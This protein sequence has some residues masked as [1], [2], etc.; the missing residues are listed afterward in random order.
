MESQAV[1]PAMLGGVTMSLSLP[2]NLV[3]QYGHLQE[4]MG[5]RRPGEVDVTCTVLLETSAVTASD[6]FS[7]AQ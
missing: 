1:H 4:E 7:G 6:Y 5:E 3:G 2:D